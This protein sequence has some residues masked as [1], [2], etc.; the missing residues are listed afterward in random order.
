MSQDMIMRNKIKLTP[1]ESTTTAMVHFGLDP[2]M[3]KC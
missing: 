1:I 2:S 3:F